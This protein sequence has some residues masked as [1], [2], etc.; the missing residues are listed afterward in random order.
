[1]TSTAQTRS[2]DVVVCGA[3]PVGLTSATL[4]A[5]RGLTVLVFEQHDYTSDEPKAISLDDEALRVFQQ[6]GIVNSV[7]PVVVPGTG[8]RYYDRN[9]EPLFHARGSM[10]YRLGYPF[11]N[12]FAQ[13]DL[14]RVL[15]D[16]LETMPTAELRFGTRVV[17]FEQADDDVRV[18]ALH[19]DQRQF[20]TAKYV[21]GCDGGRSATRLLQ[22]GTM[23]GRSHRDVW[24]VVDTIGDT[25][26]ERF[27][28]HHGDPRRPHVIV[29]G[30]NGRCRYEFRL[31][32]GEG[33]PGTAPDFELI[34]RL[35]S[36]Y[37][38]L[39]PDQVV[40]AIN[41]TFNAVVADQW[42]VGRTFLLGDAAHMMPPFAGQG[43]NSGIRDAANLTWK[44]AD[45]I[46]GRL[47]PTALDTYERERRPHALATVRLSE[48]LGRLV[49]TTSERLA[50]RRDALIGQ[51][52]QTGDGRKYLEEMR[53]RPMQHYTEGLV[54]SGDE[55]T[56]VGIAIGQP[57]AF[58]SVAHR[59][60]R[61]DDAIGGRWAV[62]AIDLPDAVWS[63]V[64][65]IATALDAD[66][67]LIPISDVWPRSEHRVLI[68]VD[69]DLN[70]EFAQYRGR[71]ML[72][73]PDKF[74]AAT[75]RP[76][77]TPDVC[78]QVLTWTPQRVTTNAAR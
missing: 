9:G 44:V 42:Q 47:A 59:V 36:C 33:E 71:F 15:A 67:A 23:S 17:G 8:T 1:M 40:R 35:V 20:V 76:I 24:M 48:Q 3:G 68:D 34:E 58:D 31:F 64:E 38:S 65:P 5:S 13:P 73:R 46:E 74:V 66:T 60:A 6:A 26:T 55:P 69:G 28:M 54:F 32:D 50:Q 29:P 19:G 7:L 56:I 78:A 63:A 70:R 62:I 2:V 53:Y 11:K 18:E 27:A 25:H 37:R 77:E 51:A 57:L 16:A 45:V 4:L 22:G 21:L 14:E 41:Y 10:P 52:V 43:L 75:W 12:P 30:L 49:M 72:L 61:L 39:S